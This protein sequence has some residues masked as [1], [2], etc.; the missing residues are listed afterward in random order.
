MRRKVVNSWR[1]CNGSV[2]EA[3]YVL[4]MSDLLEFLLSFL[5]DWVFDSCDIWGGW[6]LYLPVLSSVA[7]CALI[8]W[9]ISDPSFRN[10]LCA[11]VL[12]LGIVGGAIWQVQSGRSKL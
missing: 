4:V 11:P 7:I 5:V 9:L 8:R 2:V 12:F 1:F 3:A 6:R 10:V